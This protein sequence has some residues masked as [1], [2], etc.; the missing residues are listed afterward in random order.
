MIQIERLISCVC[1]VSVCWACVCLSV[2]VLG[3]FKCSL[4]SFILFVFVLIKFVT[5]IY[6]NHSAF[7]YDD[8]E[9]LLLESPWQS[10]IKF[11]P[12]PLVVDGERDEFR[13]PS[14]W[15]SDARDVELKLLE[16]QSSPSICCEWTP[17]IIY[18]DLFCV[19]A[20][21]NFQFESHIICGI[22]KWKLKI[23]LEKNRH[24]LCHLFCL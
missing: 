15:S 6:F 13:M 20:V 21:S 7:W 18:F 5:E 1:R 8:G 3:Y 9:S 19:T 11:S 23:W 14:G 2:C 17:G 22:E 4:S 24:S 12:L 16:L 10:T